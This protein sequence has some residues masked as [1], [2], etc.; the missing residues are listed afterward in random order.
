MPLDARGFFKEQVSVVAVTLP[1]FVASLV[2]FHSSHCAG[3]APTLGVPATFLMQSCSH[4]NL[5]GGGE[6]LGPVE[7]NP[8][9]LLFDLSILYEVAGLLVL[10]HRLSPDRERIPRMERL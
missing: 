3:A 9:A 5:P 2:I 10:L 4:R 1:L 7:F 6:V 8:A